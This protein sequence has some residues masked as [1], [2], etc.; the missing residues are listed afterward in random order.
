[1]TNVEPGMRVMTPIP[2]PCGS[3]GEYALVPSTG[4]IRLPDRVSFSQRLIYNLNLPIAYIA[5]YTFGKIQPGETILL[6]AAAGG[7]GSLIT[8]IA[9]RRGNN[10]VIAL[11]SSNRKLQHCKSN[12]ADYC[13]NYKTTDYVKKV[14]E[15]TEDRG[16]DVSLNS[17]GD[18]S[19]KTDP[20]V[21]RPMGRWVLYG[22]AAGKG[23]IDPY[24]ADTLYK[25]LTVNLFSV[26]SIFGTDIFTEA[27]DFLTDWMEDEM[28]DSV[29]KRFP[30]EDVTAAHKWLESQ[31]SYGKIVLE[32][33]TGGQKGGKSTLDPCC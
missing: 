1:M 24:A 17:V 16:V 26:Y 31:H 27:I 3:Y 18:P 28:L 9:K 29:S 23:L 10:T 13:I 20:K 33:G 30:I 21:I 32:M 25:P 8:Q 6:H 15:Y 7:V 14:L 4:V 22:M 11:A 2:M 12:G 19:L 5:Y